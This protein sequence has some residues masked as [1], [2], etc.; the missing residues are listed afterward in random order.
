MRCN[1]RET[2]EQIEDDAEAAWNEFKRLLMEKLGPPTR[3][4]D[5]PLDFS[6]WKMPDFEWASCYL[7]WTVR[8]DRHYVLYRTMPDEPEMPLFLVF[9]MLQ[10]LPPAH[11]GDLD[12]WKWRWEGDPMNENADD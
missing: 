6:S 7:L 12:P 1:D 4:H 5:E 8:P 2:L 11:E 9:G 10:A 3:M